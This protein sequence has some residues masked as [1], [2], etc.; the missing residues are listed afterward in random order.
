MFQN[1]YVELAFVHNKLALNEPDKFFPQ[2]FLH[3]KDSPE[4][5]WLRPCHRGFH[6]SLPVHCDNKPDL[7]VAALSRHRSKPFFVLTFRKLGSNRRRRILQRSFATIFKISIFYECDYMIMIAIYLKFNF[8][9]MSQ[10]ITRSRDAFFFVMMLFGM[11]AL[12]GGWAS[13]RFFR[14]NSGWWSRT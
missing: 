3:T 13:I 5:G 8:V 9:M 14:N 4:L 12:M 6:P 2:H 1:H 10:F 7:R 11:N